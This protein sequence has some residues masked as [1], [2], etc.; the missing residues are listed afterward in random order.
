VIQLSYIVSQEWL[1][2][3][4]DE[5]NIVIVDCRFMLGK[6]E[7]GR[8]LYTEDHILGAFY[9]DL[10]KDLS[11]PIMQ[12]GGR[13]P[14]PDLG[15]FSLLVG[16]LGVDAGIKVIAYDD[17]GGA[18]ASRL[19][20]MLQLLGHKEAYVLDQGYSTWKSAGLPVTGEVPT[21]TPRVF[22]PKVLRHMLA[23][24]DEVRDKF[25]RPGTVLVDSREE[26]RY[27]GIEE[28]IDRVAGHIPGAKNYFWKEVLNESGAWKSSIEQEKHF[29]ELHAADE[30]I[31]YCG[32]G[33][34]A[35]PNV[36]ALMEAGFMNVKL[37]SGSWS[38]W[39]SYEDNPIATGK[40]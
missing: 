39:V 7:S 35:C 2:E 24:F 25:E 5:P 37:Y 40:E 11:G 23:S 12:H 21:A 29:Q 33:V 19:W 17:Q 30:I 26:K 27:Q 20:W 34:T 8:I 36:L 18:M 1:S 22:S 32:S 31:V 13:H 14:L 38:D 6:P 3:H 4:L 16:R 15:A 10:E 28:S 9:V